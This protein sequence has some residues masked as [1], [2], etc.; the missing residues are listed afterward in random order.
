[1]LTLYGSYKNQRFRGMYYLHYQGGKNW[2]AR[3]NISGN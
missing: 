2:W 1:M 3:N